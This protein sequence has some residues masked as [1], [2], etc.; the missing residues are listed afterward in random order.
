MKHY[1]C[2]MQVT[3]TINPFQVGMKISSHIKK[4]LCSGTQFGFQQVDHC[5]LIS[6]DE[7]DKERLSFTHSEEQQNARLDKEEEMTAAC[8]NNQ[9][10]IFTEIKAMRKN[11]LS[12]ANTI[13]GNRRKYPSTSLTNMKNY[14]TASLT[15]KSCERSKKKYITE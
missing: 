12:F 11:T 3:H 9:N 15:R 8:L 10:G 14:I 13:D 1:Q 5:I 7:E 2:L 4:M 6:I